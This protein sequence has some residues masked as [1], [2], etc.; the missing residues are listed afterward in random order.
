[1]NK[2]F[3]ALSITL[4]LLCYNFSTSGM[5]VDQLLNM[6]DIAP[7][8]I[9]KIARQDFPDMRLVCKK[10]AHRG[11]DGKIKKDWQFMPDSVEKH[12]DQIIK[13]KKELSTFYKIIILF[14]L[15]NDYP[16]VEWMV[17]R[18]TNRVGLKVDYK[19]L[20]TPCT[21]TPAMLAIH[22]EQP[23]TARLLIE[24]SKHYK[25]Q[26][27]KDLYHKTLTI[28]KPIEECLYPGEHRNFSFIL[29]LTATWL[30]NKHN[31]EKLYHHKI[32]T[33]SGQTVL[34]NACLYNNAIK[35]FKFLSDRTAIQETIKH[36]NIG[37]FILTI[38]QN[39]PKFA[40]IYIKK[41]LYPINGTFKENDKTVTM[42]DYYY[43]HETYKN[44]TQAHA[45]LRSLGA[46]TT[47]EI[48]HEQLIREEQK[49]KEQRRRGY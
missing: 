22:Y 27:W 35:C 47:K 24:T 2:A 23:E 13:Q 30:D 21:I 16:A 38:N 10:W 20:S 5:A 19:C 46:K 37:F 41:K 43:Q 17:N 15:I 33:T 4:H 11:I 12:Y 36:N 48:Q 34:I 45:L 39:N 29:Y 32:P 3:I 40:K 26:N 44:N 28:P 1:M 25:D 18:N 9:T 49:R 8:I 7:H 6:P 31:L 42:L 14:D